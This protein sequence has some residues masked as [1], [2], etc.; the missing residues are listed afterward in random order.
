MS[1]LGF[2][3]VEVSSEPPKPFVTIKKSL[4]DDHITCL[5]CGKAYKSLRRHI[6]AHHGQTPEDYRAL[7]KLPD[8]YPMVAKEYSKKRS[9]I[10]IASG[11]GT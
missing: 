8:D 10:A 3:A 11:L 9:E 4:A 2:S 6:G 5:F 1:S 7:W